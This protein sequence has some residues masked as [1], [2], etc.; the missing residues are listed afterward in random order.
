MNIIHY[1]N[2][3]LTTPT[4][5]VEVFDEA[6]LKTLDNMYELMLAYNGIGLAANQCGLD[7][8]MFII[9]H[10]DSYKEFVN[11]AITL[12]D[13]A[14]LMREGCLSF[15]GVILEVSR[16]E[17]VTVE[18]QDKHGESFK[19]A[20]EGLEARVVLHEAAHL[21]GKTFLD[22]VNRQQRKAALRQIE[23][24]MK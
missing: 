13:S 7:K 16:P 15:P 24:N 18:A 1:P 4:K 9:K 17:Y 21:L 2:Q 10:K 8:S 6:L 20:L 3:I 19:V 12:T 22:S 5:R 23:R 14:I 11:P